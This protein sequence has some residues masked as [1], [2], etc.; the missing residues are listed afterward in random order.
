VAEM[1][2]VCKPGGY[3]VFMNHFM[4]EKHWLRPFERASSSLCY[5]ILGFRTD[6]S[7]NRLVE[8]HQLKVESREAF[9]FMGNWTAVRCLVP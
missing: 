8:E 5:R 4:T 2:R 1:K 3:L 6:V 7:L 9:G